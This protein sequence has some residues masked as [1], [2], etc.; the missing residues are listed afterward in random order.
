MKLTISDWNL[1]EK[2]SSLKTLRKVFSYCLRFI[3]NLKNKQKLT[4]SLSEAELIASHIVI[5]K[6]TQASA[7]SKEINA[8]TNSI[9]ISP[10]SSLLQLNPFLDNGILKV[11][12]R[13]EY[14]QIPETQ[15]SR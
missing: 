2:Y 10:K 12:G 9:S 5:I 8:I 11:G 1:L 7:F 14:A 3:H 6:I 15:K 4:G 13:L